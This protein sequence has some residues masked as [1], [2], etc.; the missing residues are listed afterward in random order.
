MSQKICLISFDHWNYDQHIILALKRKNI[1]C[2]HIKIGQFKHKNLWSKI[3][4]TLSKVFLNKNPKLIKRQ[5]YILKTLRER[6]IQDQIL[7]INPELIDL[8]YHLKIKKYTSKYIAYLYDSVARCSVSNL[9]DG[10]FDEIYS[11]DADDIKNYHFKPTTNY[12]YIINKPKAV[13]IKTAVLYLASFDNR[14]ENL[15]PLKK[16]LNQKNQS[17]R[18]IIIGKKTSVYKILHLF[19]E[20]I[21]QLELRRKR[22]NQSQLIEL[23]QESKIIL[24]LVRPHQTGLSFRIFEAMALEKKV[25]T[26]NKNILN[27]NFYNPNNI[28]VIDTENIVINSDFFETEYQPLTETIYNQYTINNWVSS[29]FKL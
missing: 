7:V 18:F 11:F 22:I 3:T 10:V 29:I 2:F 15:I 12:N 16:Y 25:I 17:F 27:Y 28:A 26:N 5:E 14:L 6:G 24:D 19:S 8:N 21:K 9:L 4:N 1:D 20:K 23:Y 13:S